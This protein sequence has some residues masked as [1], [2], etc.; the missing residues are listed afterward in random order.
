MA[1]NDSDYYGD[2]CYFY[3]D[4]KVGSFGGDV[5]CLQQFL[6]HEDVMQEEPSGY[7]GG[8]TEAALSRWQAGNGLMPAKGILGYSSRVAYARKH[9]LPTAEQLRSLEH[10]AEVAGKTCNIESCVQ[11]GSVEDICRSKVVTHD[12]PYSTR[13]HMCQEACQA[14]MSEACDKAFPSSHSAAFKD[15]LGMVAKSCKRNCEQ[16]I[17]R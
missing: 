14:A 1:G 17:A 11:I 16:T 4:L 8:A 9:D 7:F 2:S 3:R 13:M 10:E 15:C 6:R 12:A 5:S